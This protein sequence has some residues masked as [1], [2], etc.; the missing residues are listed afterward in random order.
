M[1]HLPRICTVC[2][3]EYYPVSANQK[4]CAKCNQERTLARGVVHH[5]TCIRCGKEYIAHSDWQKYCPDCGPIVRK[6]TSHRWQLEH[7]S[8]E[9]RPPVY[10][11]K[12]CER[13]ICPQCGREYRPR[14]N[15]QA[16]CS[17][18]IAEARELSLGRFPLPRG[19]WRSEYVPIPLNQP[20]PNCEGHHIDKTHIVY[21][22]KELHQSVHHD[23]WGNKNMVRINAL[24]LE[25]LQRKP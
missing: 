8:S 25:Y 4:R 1:E 16:F 21:I 24:A 9:K 17:A 18:C 15:G 3:Q 5:G 23:L 6:E 11:T 20:F 13:R 2:G 19:N 7:P 14:K 10:Q 22:P 12:R